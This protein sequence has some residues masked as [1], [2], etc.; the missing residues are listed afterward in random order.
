[1]SSNNLAFT[2]M[3]ISLAIMGIFTYLM[4]TRGSRKKKK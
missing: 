1:M 3:Y 4:W 2:V